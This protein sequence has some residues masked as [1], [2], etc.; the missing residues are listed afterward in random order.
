MKF[1]MMAVAVVLVLSVSV[2]FS[3]DI[4]GKWKGKYES[5]MGGEPMNMEYTFKADGKELKGTTIGGA[6][7]EQIPLLDGKIDGNKISFTVKVDLGGMEMVFKYKGELDKDK[8]KLK[9]EMDGMG[10]GG[11][12]FTV[13]RA[14]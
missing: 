3:A 8:L 12:E 14:K 6:N 9:F 7:G 5:G 11:G 2:A 10:G 1:R 4:D 13:E